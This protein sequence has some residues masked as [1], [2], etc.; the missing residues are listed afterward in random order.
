MWPENPRV[1]TVVA[2]RRV[3]LGAVFLFLDCLPVR[4]PACRCLEALTPLP[5]GLILE[6]NAA[7]VKVVYGSDANTTI[8]GAAL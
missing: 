8:A 3:G 1:G 6:T 2:I 7:A 5:D 4:P